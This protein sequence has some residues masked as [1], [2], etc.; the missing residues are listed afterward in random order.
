MGV[1][2]L[3]G[4]TV[5]IAL[6]ANNPDDRLDALACGEDDDLAGGLAAVNQQVVPEKIP[7]HVQT[8]GDG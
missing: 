3:D 7:G 4:P 1:E 6:V 5:L 8:G 2:P